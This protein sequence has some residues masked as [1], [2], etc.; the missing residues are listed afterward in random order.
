MS[1]FF[2]TFTAGEPDDD[3]DIST[4]VELTV[5]NTS[6]VPIYQVQYR[7]WF[8]GDQDICFDENDSYEDVFLAPGDSTTISPWG[9]VNQRDLQEA[10]ISVRAVGQLCRREYIKLGELEIPA[11][12][13]SARL[14]QQVAFDWY[15]GPLTV[16]FSRT[17]PDS[18]GDFSLEFKCLIHNQTSRHLKS[19]T[20]KA[21][22]LD[23]D[24]VEIESSESEEEIHAET[25][26]LISGS[27]WRPKAGQIEGGKVII[28]L[29]ALV[30]A[31]RFEASETTDLSSD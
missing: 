13:E 25:A 21:Q 17:E 9:R 5:T 4:E 14:H 20:L 27:F 19:I 11:T 6:S 7:M 3:G 2:S 22:L 18:D 26:K 31:E 12:G 16:L 8:L 28:A 30:P 1:A 29:K 10:S 23:A 15:Q 24:G